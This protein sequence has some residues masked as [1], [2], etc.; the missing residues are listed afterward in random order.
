VR[1]L[2]TVMALASVG[3]AQKF[4]A[5]KK[6]KGEGNDHS[7]SGGRPSQGQDAKTGSMAGVK[8]TD[9]R[10][11]YA[12]NTKCVPSPRSMEYGHVPGLTITAEGVGNANISWK[13][14]RSTLTRMRS[15]FEGAPANRRLT[16]TSQRQQGTGRRP[17]AGWSAAGDAC[18]P[19]QLKRRL[20]I[21]RQVR[22]HRRPAVCRL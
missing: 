11:F 7:R 20:R 8:I 21:T 4:K 12:T 1:A 5:G 6:G 9:D 22:W 15:R 14:A 2:L 10:K 16:P 13:R 3:F 17:T 19:P 18:S